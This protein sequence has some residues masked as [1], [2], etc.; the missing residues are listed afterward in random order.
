MLVVD[1][2]DL[3]RLGL[4]ALLDSEDGFAVAGEAAD[5]LAAVEE[6]APPGRTW[7]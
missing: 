5:G 1:D 7:C 4:S 3:V 6:A 2:Q